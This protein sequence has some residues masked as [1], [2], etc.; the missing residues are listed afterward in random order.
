MCGNEESRPAENAVLAASEARL[1]E[2]PGLR[3]HRISCE[4]RDGTL[5]LRGHV[6][7]YSLKQAAQAVVEGVDGVKEVDN[8]LDVIPLPARDLPGNSDRGD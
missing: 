8:Q 7:S 2:S 6:P 5:T 3:E 4:F 1:R